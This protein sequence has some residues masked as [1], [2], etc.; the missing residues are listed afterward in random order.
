MSGVVREYHSWI[1]TDNQ[2]A[3][4]ASATRAA[5]TG[6]VRHFVTSVSGSFSATETAPL[7]LRQGTT[8]IGR[9]YVYDSFSLSFSSPIVIEPGNLVELELTAVTNT[10]AVTLTG[11]TA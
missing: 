3:G 11:Y 5:P 6:G 7:I 2:A 1:E 4:E 8:E 10:A 9:W